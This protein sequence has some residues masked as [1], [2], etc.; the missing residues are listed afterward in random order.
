MR[1]YKTAEQWE[2]VVHPR[3]RRRW[4]C[5][6]LLVVCCCRRPPFSATFPGASLV[7]P[8]TLV[9]DCPR[10]NARRLQDIAVSRPWRGRGA[11][12][13]DS[14]GLLGGGSGSS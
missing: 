13:S 7:S 1:L 9:H 14:E 2:T 4:R 5:Q 11:R 3:A 12:R 6:A 8:L 10:F